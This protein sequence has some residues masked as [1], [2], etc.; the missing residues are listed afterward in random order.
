MEDIYD[1]QLSGR[2]NGRIKCEIRLNK[3]M[4]KKR[5]ETKI[6]N[7]Q[8]RTTI[9]QENATFGRRTQGA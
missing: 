5:R 3:N 4:F 8:E 7:V 9:T 2:R 1:C 6:V